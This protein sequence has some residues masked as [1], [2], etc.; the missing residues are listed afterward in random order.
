MMMKVTLKMMMIWRKERMISLE[1]MKK[2]QRKNMK[3]K[4]TKAVRKKKK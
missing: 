2:R 1:M 4:M 3:S